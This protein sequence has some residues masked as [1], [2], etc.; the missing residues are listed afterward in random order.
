MSKTPSVSDFGGKGI[1]VD[2][3]VRNNEVLRITPRENLEVNEYWMPDA[4]WRDLDNRSRE[5][6]LKL[7]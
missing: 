1:N 4:A 7:S 5:L 6:S 3:W 2:L